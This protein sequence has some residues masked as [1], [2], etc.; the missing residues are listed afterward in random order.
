MSR[1]TLYEKEEDTGSTFIETRI[2]YDM[3]NAQYMFCQY[4]FK[5]TKLVSDNCCI[6]ELE[7]MSKCMKSVTRLHMSDFFKKYKAE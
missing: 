7:E 1:I 4:I 2:Y 6:I 3:D 5:G